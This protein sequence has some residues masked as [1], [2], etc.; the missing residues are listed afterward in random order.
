MDDKLPVFCHIKNT[1]IHPLV[2]GEMGVHL[3]GGV[4]LLWS[5]ED[6]TVFLEMLIVGC[7]CE[8]MLADGC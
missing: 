5:P 6:L 8:Q 7:V 1:N 4:E 2:R 3:I